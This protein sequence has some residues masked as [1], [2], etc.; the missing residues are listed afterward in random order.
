MARERISYRESDAEEAGIKGH[1]EALEQARKAK[2]TF[3][4]M[5]W[6]GLVAED[7]RLR[8]ELERLQSIAARIPCTENQILYHKE[9]MARFK[10]TYGL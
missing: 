10:E 8:R 9:K 3:R 1:Y 2:L 6:E 4:E 7:Y 5:L